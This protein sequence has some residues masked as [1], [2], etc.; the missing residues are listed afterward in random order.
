MS[1][2]SKKDDVPELPRAPTLP[3]LPESHSAPASKAHMLPAMAPKTGDKL[4]NEMV[5]SAV[6]DDGH[7]EHM[8]PHAMKPTMSIPATHHPPM[9]EHE[10]HPAEDH[11]KEVFVKLDKF[12]QAQKTFMQMKDKLAQI[13]ILVQKA[14]QINE[15]EKSELANWN[16][17]LG[18][19][20]SKVREI[21]SEVFNQ[22]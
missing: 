4:N 7:N 8:V 11:K 1:L 18:D 12:T 5:K 17:S 13:E 6:T 2:F 19:L 10:P 16:K 3:K 15:R 21:D 9:S 20:K 14:E 22:V